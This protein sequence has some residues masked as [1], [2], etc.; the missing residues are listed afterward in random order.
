M[1]SLSLSAVSKNF[2][3][4][5]VLNSLSLEISS[6]ELFFCSDHQDAAKPLS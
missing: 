5:R 1:T 6:S 4:T 2:G 3:T